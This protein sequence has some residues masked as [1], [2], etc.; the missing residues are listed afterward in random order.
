[1]DGPLP[2]FWRRLNYCWV[3]STNFW[4]Q[5]VCWHHPAMFCLINSSK[6]EF[7]LMVR[8]MRSNLSYLLKFFL[9]YLCLSVTFAFVVCPQL[10]ESWLVPWHNHQGLWNRYHT[11][12]TIMWHND[13]LS[14]ISWVGCLLKDWELFILFA[15]N[16]QI[17]PK[18]SVIPILLTF[19]Y[20]VALNLL[21][22]NQLNSSHHCGT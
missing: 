1:M 8:R 12:V 2:I 22:N 5:K 6:L 20:L 18:I 3:L 17:F 13:E 16:S 9:H 21:V 15:E 19:I 11:N 7:S 4:E 14:S 10:F